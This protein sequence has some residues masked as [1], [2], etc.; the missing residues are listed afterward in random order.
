MKKILVARAKKDPKNQPND[1]EDLYWSKILALTKDDGYR[2]KL[3]E[4]ALRRQGKSTQH[5]FEEN[6]MKVDDIG[7]LSR[8]IGKVTS[9][10]NILFT[11]MLYLYAHL[12]KKH[13]TVVSR[14][15]QSLNWVTSTLLFLIFYRII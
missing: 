12:R 13:S 6:T 7:I 15:L 2:R 5:G 4:M 9:S 14:L 8:S 11:H 10:L 1:V 3:E